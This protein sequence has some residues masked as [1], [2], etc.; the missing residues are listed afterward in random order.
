M[1]LGIRYH[2][3]SPSTTSSAADSPLPST[4]T[5]ATAEL[6]SSSTTSSAAGSLL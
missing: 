2:I 1:K 6:A 3:A 4:T 5:I